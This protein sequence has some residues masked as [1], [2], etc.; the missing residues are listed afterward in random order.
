M[1]HDQ[2]IIE[3]F[4][5]RANTIDR[6]TDEWLSRRLKPVALGLLDHQFIGI[7]RVQPMGPLYR[8]AATSFDGRPAFIL[9]YL[10]SAE[11]HKHLDLVDDLIAVDVQTG[12]AWSR[13]PGGTG[14]LITSYMGWD[15]MTRGRRQ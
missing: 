15:R 14:S 10:S 4:E 2:L 11:V 7:D 6:V 13:R 8:P 5:A 9:P 1:S 12:Q 3:L